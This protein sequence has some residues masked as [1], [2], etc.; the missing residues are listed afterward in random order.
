MKTYS[1]EQIRV[2]DIRVRELLLRQRILRR[3]DVEKALVTLPDLA[4][5]SVPEKQGQPSVL[6]QPALAVPAA[7]AQRPAFYEN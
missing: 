2:M 5:S 7:R 6:A 3:E 4:N 1:L